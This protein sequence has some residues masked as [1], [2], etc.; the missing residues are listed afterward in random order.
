MI[1]RRLSSSDRMLLMNGYEQIKSN[2]YNE[3][4]SNKFDQ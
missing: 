2:K 4:S 1:K 3:H